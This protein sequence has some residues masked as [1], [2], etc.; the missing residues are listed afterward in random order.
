[1]RQ[2]FRM[3]N[4]V[5]NN[6]FS[7][8]KIIE[9]SNNSFYELLKDDKSDPNKVL[10]KEEENNEIIENI[11]SHLSSNERVIFDLK[12][13][14]LSNGEIATLIDKNKKYIE[15]AMFRINRKY[16]ELF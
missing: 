1:M 10:L 2:S 4:R 14:G 7:L 12:L 3:K 5:L 15:N 6:S 16:K 13:K 8:D 11:R 9:N